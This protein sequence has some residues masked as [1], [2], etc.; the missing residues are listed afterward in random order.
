MVKNDNDTIPHPK[1]YIIHLFLSSKKSFGA[2]LY[3]KGENRKQ[4]ETTLIC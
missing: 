3:E 4:G 2:V 1:I